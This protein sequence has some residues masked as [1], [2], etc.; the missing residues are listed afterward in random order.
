MTTESKQNAGVA[1]DSAQ[2]AGSIDY[3]ICFNQQ[4]RAPKHNCSVAVIC[5]EFV[6]IANVKPNAAPQTGAERA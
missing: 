1:T 2:A 6:T 5:K 4:C 3:S